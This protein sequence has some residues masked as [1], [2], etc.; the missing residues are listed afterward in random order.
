[1]FERG[2]DRI[3][4]RRRS[5]IEL[6]I[7]SST[8]LGERLI[9]FADPHELLAFHSGFEGHLVG[10]GWT[11][12]DF[13]PGERASSLGESHSEERRPWS[14][15]RIFNRLRRGGATKPLTSS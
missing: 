1:V 15:L 8:S 9:T 10:S 3:H 2:D 5:D 11:L 4:V 6:T 14:P 7:F 13:C 12:A